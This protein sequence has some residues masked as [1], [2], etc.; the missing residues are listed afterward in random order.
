[1]RTSAARSLASLLIL[2]A[3]ASTAT[4]AGIDRRASLA[5]GDESCDDSSPEVAT[6]PD[7]TFLVVWQRCSSPSRIAAQRLDA[8]G[9]KLGAQIDLGSGDFPQVAALPDRGYAI[10]FLREVPSEVNVF[11]VYA[12]RLDPTGAALADAVR[13]DEGGGE[14]NR[15][16]YAV[17]RLAAAPD[18]RLF[19][20]WRNM[21]LSPFPVP[22][23][24]LP[25]LGRMLGADLVPLGST[26]DLG[27]AG[28]LD[29]IDVSFD[30]QGR[31][32]AV[33]ALGSV[34]ARRYGEA[35]I[36][37][38]I[39]VEV[40]GGSI[41]AFNPH[42]APRPGG[43][44]WLA[45][46]EREGGTQSGFTRAFLRPLDADGH[47]AGPRIDVGL[48][49]E[50]GATEPVPGVDPDGFVLVAGHDTQGAIKM[51]LFDP[52][53]APASD[54][55]SLANPDPF[56]LGIASLAESSATGFNAFWPGDATNG[57]FPGALRGWDLRGALLASSCPSPNAVCARVGGAVA[58]VE[59]RWRL[60]GR[61]G[62][63]RGLRLG[64][65]L[66]FALENPGRFDVAVD[67]RGGAIDWAA[68]TNAEI[69]IRWTEAGT[70]RT[71]IKPAG[72]FASG[73]LG[74]PTPPASIAMTA[75]VVSEPTGAL[76]AESCAPSARTAC[77]L[78]GRFRVV[79]FATGA[80]GLERQAEALAFA[81]RQAILSFTEAGGATLSLL[82]GRASNGKLWVYWGGLSTA[83]FRIQVTDLSTGTTR[84]YANPAGQRQSRADRQAF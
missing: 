17:P 49:G 18:G 53:G 21:F 77:L 68:T 26:F 54:L 13:V 5:L 72:R 25:T 82:D 24:Q 31:A 61:S 65:H 33:T 23:F 1:M 59:V 20:G 78:G 63:G 43:G 6:Q 7:G 3:F 74:S 8:V 35:G 27:T 55:A 76:A 57:P 10:V 84:T 47:P 62:A 42:L 11:G 44:W 12:R 32:L 29:D 28:I 45:W 15:V 52:T 46:E 58:E 48:I 56:Q 51:R 19:V 34:G 81:D 9:R 14:E 39:A 36:P 67:L 60:A 66:L 73:H 4:A 79:A 50:F 38:G 83:A 37:I 69:T 75:D 16:A 40:G 71:A 22:I 80:D 30:E 2:F 70:T 41:P 64:H